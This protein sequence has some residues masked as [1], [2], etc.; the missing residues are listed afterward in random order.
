MVDGLEDALVH[1]FG[2]SRRKRES[3]L[4]K[5]IR[6]SLNS[7]T[8]GSVAKVRVPR[9]LDWIMVD[10][11][12]LVQVASDHLGDFVK[13]VVVELAILDVGR[14]PEGGQ[15]AHGNLVGAGVLDNLGCKRLDDFIVPRFFWFDLWLHASL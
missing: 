1:Q 4:D 13:L 11:N 14:K 2:I 7:K 12:D 15:V 9:F 8:N 5:G 10:V 6:Q 3:H